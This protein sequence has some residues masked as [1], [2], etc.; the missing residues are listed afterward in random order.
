MKFIQSDIKYSGIHT[1][2][3]QVLDI[4]H[5]KR[6][7]LEYEVTHIH[8]HDDAAIT[9]KVWQHGQLLGT[10]AS[11][12]GR[13]SPTKQENSLWYA[14]MSPN[15]KKQRGRQNSKF[16]KDATA[17]AR[18]AIE[19]LTKKPLPIIGAEIIH[20]ISTSV[21]WVYGRVKSLYINSLETP[22]LE[23]AEYFIEH[24]LGNNPSPPAKL[25]AQI[26]DEL[27][28]KRENY[29]IAENVM[30]YARSS[31]GYMVYVMQDETLLV[32]PLDNPEATA[33]YESTYELPEFM[34]EKITMIKLLEPNQFAADIG[35][36]TE[37]THENNKIIGYFVVG[38]ATVVH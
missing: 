20:S 36:Q 24:K 9:V 8:V 7:L 30:N 1:R 19:M 15:I 37:I 3:Q 35:I 11:S 29:K 16:S 26:T 17:A 25:M 14:V 21:G 23:L 13:Y 32:A 33:K 5:A 2:L 22:A 31:N 28:R 38:G 10:I 27:L 12:F 4:V 34:Q 18:V 6:P